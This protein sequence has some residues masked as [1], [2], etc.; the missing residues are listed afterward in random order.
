MKNDFFR[1]SDFRKFQRL[2][3]GSIFSEF[4]LRDPMRHTVYNPFIFYSPA[5]GIINYCAFVKPTEKILFEGHY[6]IT[7]EELVKLPIFKSSHYYVLSIFMTAASV[8]INRMPTTGVITLMRE[9]EPLAID[10]YSMLPFERAYFDEELPAPQAALYQ[11]LNERIV[12]EIYYPRFQYYYIIVQIADKDVDMIN[13]YA[14]EGDSLSQGER[15][16]EIRWG[17]D[18]ILLLPYDERFEIES[19]VN[20]SDYV[21][22]GITPVFRIKPKDSNDKI[23]Y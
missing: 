23:E 11:R 5:D 12:L 6:I 17:S 22:A 3:W 10:N 21:Y 19:L 9:I 7:P 20:P 1:S 15:F 2:D 4:F 13:N 14:D 18:V 8:H 16:G